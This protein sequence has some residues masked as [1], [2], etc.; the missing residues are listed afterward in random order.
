[1][2]SKFQ[3]IIAKHQARLEWENRLFDRLGY[4]KILAVLALVVCITFLFASRFAV[5]AIFATLAFFAV[6]VVLWVW[7]YRLDNKIR[8]A[9][10]IVAICNRHICRITG[11]WA[12]FDDIGKEFI[13]PVHP[14]ACDLDIVG[15]KSFFQFL[16]TTRT[17]HGRQAFAGD[18]LNP[19]YT[20]EQIKERQR[21]IAELSKDIEFANDIQYYLSQI[22]INPL[23]AELIDELADSKPFMKSIVLKFSICFVPV[24]TIILLLS[25]FWVRGLFWAGALF[26]VVQHL[27]CWFSGCK[28]R[29]YLGIM[30]RLP[31]KLGKY[32]HVIDTLRMRDFSSHKL[33]E[34]KSRLG[35]ASVAVKELEKISNA[36][37]IMS[38]PIVYVI[39]N[40]FL[41]W[42]FYCAFL[43]ERWKGKYS[44]LAGEWF[45]AIGE[46][47][48]LLAFSHLP[49]VCDGVCLPEVRESGKVL[50]AKGLGHPLLQNSSRVCNS[51]RFDN[52]IFIISGSNMSGKT[53]F[54]RTVGVNLLLARAGSFVCASEMTCSRF[55]IITSMRIADDLNQGVSTF[56]AELKRIKMILD[57]VGQNKDTMFLIDEIF[58]GTNSVD[59]LAG[60]D[61]VITKLQGLGGA[62]M[63]STHDLELCKLADMHDRIVNYSFSEDYQDG[64][65]YFDYKLRKGQ[66]K[67][68]NAR[69]LMEMVG[70]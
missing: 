32:V 70:I 42:D 2:Q 65:I 45:A 31:Y 34:I 9:K 52:N 6:S 48:S 46:F 16:N 41:L 61:A 1:M 58:K 18:L 36:L 53:T 22:G 62:G 51:L 55:D 25:G 68:T 39:F 24:V 30:S 35:V 10:G 5:P 49:N 26:F 37:S 63:V 14:F 38:N 66:S 57:V 23:D 8:Y 17:W 29:E 54:M 7:H 12:N 60:A 69:F 33:N 47:E 28:A 15:A 67:T 59:R 56:Y 43:L 40:W 44:H 64:S 11:D 50:E 20:I 19:A 3:D 27:L 21:A 4:G 13:D